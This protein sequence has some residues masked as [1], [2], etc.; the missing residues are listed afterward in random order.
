MKKKA[1]AKS[2]GHFGWTMS[3]P[4]SAAA[5]QARTLTNAFGRTEG[6]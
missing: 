1:L 4:E 2:Q 5:V 3:A 6:F